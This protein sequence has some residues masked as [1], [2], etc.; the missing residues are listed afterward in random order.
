MLIVENGEVHPGVE[1]FLPTPELHAYVSWALGRPEV[2]SM[3][4][5]DRLSGVLAAA[6]WAGEEARL[7][8]VNL[9]AHVRNEVHYHDPGAGD[10]CLT[11]DSRA[12]E[13]TRPK[14]ID[15]NTPSLAE[16]ETLPGIGLAKAKTIIDYREQSGRFGSVQQ[17]MEV[18][19]IGPVT[20]ESI[21][22]LVYFEP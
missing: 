13:G 21:L 12:S 5:G 20:P 11:G 16:L 3:R 18:A 19:G 9:A 17:I 2:D 10:P 8:C 14:G 15:L 7:P 4:D 22:D 6:G 1:V